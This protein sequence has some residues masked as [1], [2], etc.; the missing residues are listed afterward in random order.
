MADHGLGEALAA[1]IETA[2]AAER[3]LFGALDGRVL[4]RP[5][6]E[7]DWNP[8]DFQA[9]LTAWKDRHAERLA[10]IRQGR[11]PLPRSEAQEEDAINAELRAERV[12]WAWDAL[13]A[14]A[15]AVAER[16]AGELRLA[17]PDVLRGPDRLVD[18][19]FGNGLMH[20]LSHLRWL[21]EAGVPL[22]EARVARYEADALRVATAPAIPDRS[23]AAETY[24]LACHHALRGSLDV[25]RQLL[26]DAFHRDPE[27]LEFGRTDSDLAALRGELDDLAG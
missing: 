9:H 2:R 24:N 25:A 4:E 5:I 23:T 8:K 16:L 27:L 11:E 3:D 15:D 20:T 21:L 19:T 12:D 18:L 14:E 7:G 13:V 17:D 22:D 6:R 10:R 26:R 1:T